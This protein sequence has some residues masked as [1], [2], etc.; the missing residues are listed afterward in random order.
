MYIFSPAAAFCTL[1]R[2]A[3]PP[4]GIILLIGPFYSCG[5][6]TLQRLIS[7]AA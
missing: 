7:R 6:E 4:N 3:S 2:A 5:S 1:A